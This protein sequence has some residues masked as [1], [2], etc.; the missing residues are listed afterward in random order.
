M[1]T[2][3]LERLADWLDSILKGEPAVIGVGFTERDLEFTIDGAQRTLSVHAHRDFLPPWIED[4]SLTT[5]IG[6]PLHQVDLEGAILS[7][8]SQLR[9]FPDRPKL[10]EF[11]G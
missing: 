6:F 10:D 7:L 2:V 3:E 8:R 4:R 11:H 5:T 9:A 1:D